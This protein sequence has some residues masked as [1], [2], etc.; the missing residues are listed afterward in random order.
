MNTMEISD[1]PVQ[2]Q[3]VEYF[4]QLVRIA[5]ADDVVSIPETDLLRRTGKKIGFTDIEISNII[6][7]TGK[8]DYT[9]PSELSERF[10]QAYNIVKMTLADGAIDKN[11]MRLASGFAIKSG[12]KENEVPKLLLLLIDGAKQLK[13]EKELF[14]KY[15]KGMGI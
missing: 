8:S 1:Q 4:V 9:P 10:E 3:N 11:E 5:M 12:F 2:K 6:E 13:D 14:E 15:K 7:T